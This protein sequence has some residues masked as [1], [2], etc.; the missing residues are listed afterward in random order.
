MQY[1]T[2][3]IDI[4]HESVSTTRRLTRGRAARDDHDALRLVCAGVL[5]CFVFVYVW[6]RAR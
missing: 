1:S 2:I 3:L 4:R 6:S 5:G